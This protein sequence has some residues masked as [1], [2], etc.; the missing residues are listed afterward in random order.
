MKSSRLSTVSIGIG[1]A[2]ILVIF[3]VLCLTIFSVLSFTTAYSDLKLSRK[4]EQMT[5]DYY[6]IHGKA[7][8]K[9][10]EI[11]E[12]L[13]LVQKDLNIK[14][15]ESISEAYNFNK[16]AEEKIAEIEGIKV[17]KLDENNIYSNLAIYYEV[18]GDKNQ[19]ICVT[20]NILYDDKNDTPY[21]KIISW[22][23]SNIELP[24]YDEEIYDLWK[25]I[26]E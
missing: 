21:Y 9:L 1:G 25:G 16:S 13:I 2:L 11:S 3:I 10:A 6:T 4:T 18:L 14:Y 15:D 12:K 17:F 5:E 19:K 22:N 23:L 8:E 26:D 7:E 24:K 20:L